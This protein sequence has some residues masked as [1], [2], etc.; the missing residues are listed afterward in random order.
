MVTGL[1]LVE[2]QL[3]TAEGEHLP[4]SQDQIS[5][6]GHAI[7]VRLYA[8][9]A[10][11]GYLPQTGTIVAL[12]LPT[13]EGIRCDHALVEGGEVTAHYDP[14]VAKLIAHGPDRKTATMRL[15]RALTELTLLGVRHN[16]GFLREV[17]DH[18][19]FISGDVHT[20]WLE[21]E[22]WSSVS[23]VSAGDVAIAGWLMLR[24]R[25][26]SGT[27]WR[28]SGPARSWVDLHSADA[29]FRVHA[30]W[31]SSVSL[32]V[33]GCGDGD[34][35]FDFTLV[36]VTDRLLRAELDG[37]RRT[38]RYAHDPLGV[39][40]L[41]AGAE[42]IAFVEPVRGAS[43]EEADGDGR[44][45]APMSGRVVAV[46]VE[47]GDRVERGAPLLTLEAMKLQSPL[48]APMN[49]VV[50]AVHVTEGEQVKGGQLLV[51]M[52]GA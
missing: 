23:S 44:V 3:R 45:R 38:W 24:S 49:G 28:S 1:D 36:S 15:R 48:A 52:E 46:S 20:G 19:E 34:Q 39:L 16:A 33:S 11:K 12:T 22:S 37:I 50:S 26:G 30:A 27:G 6:D 21:A 47:V 40:H 14:M 43:E 32:T 7:E 41:Q 2:L 18:P 10:R 25:G 35:A 4:W 8:E 31:G 51:E 13:G 9:D 17:L 42:P 5:L 29:R